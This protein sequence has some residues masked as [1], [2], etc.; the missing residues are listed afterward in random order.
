M[1]IDDAFSDMAGGE[2]NG[3]F[4]AEAAA[5]DAGLADFDTAKTTAQPHG[6]TVQMRCRGCGRTKQLVVEY[7][8]L[9]A[10]K[11]NVPPQ[12]AFRGQA[13]I[14]SS[15]AEWKFSHKNRAWYPNSPCSSC[16]HPCSPLFTPEEAEMHLA[17]ARRGGWINP[18]AE[19]SVSQIAHSVGVQLQQQQQQR[20]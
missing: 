20:R 16:Q 10:I 15:P 11:Y 5:L 19:K 18:V 13:N 6:V 2:Q 7:P 1:S 8:E 17:K 14:I 4:G 3:I 12:I 9:V